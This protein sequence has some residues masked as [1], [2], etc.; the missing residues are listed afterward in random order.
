MLEINN[1]SLENAL[2]SNNIDFQNTAISFAHL[3]NSELKQ[4]AWLFRMMNNPFL[5][6]WGSAWAVRL[7]DMGF[8][9]VEKI[10]QQTIYKQFCGGTTLLNALSTIQKLGKHQVKTILDFGVEAKQNE[11]DFNMTM[12][13]NIRA[14]EFANHSAKGDIPFIGIKVTGLCRFALLEKLQSNTPLTVE[15]NEEYLNA[16]KRIDAICYKAREKGVSVMIDA[17]ESWVQDSIDRIADEM[18]RRYNTKSAIVFNTF[19]MYRHDRL[20][21]LKASHEKALQKGYILGAKLVRGAYMEK[22]RQRAAEKGYPTPIN[23]DKVATDKLY[24]DA[25]VFCANHYDK[26][27]ICNAT[28]NALST[29]LLVSLMTELH[30]EASNPHVWFCQ[31]YGMSDNLTF[32]LAARGYNVAKYLPYGNVHDVVPYLVRRAQENTTVTGDM[33]REYTLIS[34]ELKRR[35][36]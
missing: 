4:M 14:L 2:P 11:T 15:D 10:I 28:H 8:P 16:F 36:S 31:L 35:N 19:Q 7:L 32:N 23:P 21:F 33:S 17:E 9:F 5:V 12:T 20:H 24:N 25:L 6:R 29:Q 27:A 1:S 26:I 13:E 22:E 3:N 30:I 34:K 18:M